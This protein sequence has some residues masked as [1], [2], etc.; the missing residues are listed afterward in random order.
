MSFKYEV[1]E[2]G[3]Y[4]CIC[5]IDFSEFPPMELIGNAANGLEWYI[6]HCPNCH[7]E[8]HLCSKYIAVKAIQAKAMI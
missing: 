2:I 4:S 7:S 8:F 3:K 5:G 1:A 6:F